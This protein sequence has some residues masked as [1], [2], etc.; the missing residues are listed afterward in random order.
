[1]KSKILII[2]SACS[3]TKTCEYN[4]GSFAVIKMTVEEI[5]KRIPK[6]ELS[7]L[8]QL[9]KDN[10]LRNK[11]FIIENK[12]RETRYYSL[13]D[14]L[15]MDLNV[16]SCLLYRILQRVNIEANFMK[17]NKIIRAFNDAD[18]IIDLSLDAFS[19]D[20]G[21]RSIIE[22]SKE[23]L[24]GIFLD[25]PV[26]VY[27]QSLG[28][29]NNRLNRFIARYVLNRTRII[30]VRE[31]VSFHYIQELGLDGPDIYLTADQAFLLKPVSSMEL[32][33]ILKSENI[34]EW[35]PTVGI[36]LSKMKEF[37]QTSNILKKIFI[38]GY[39]I[40]MYLLPEI[41]VKSLHNQI[42]KSKYLQKVEPNFG[43]S[44]IN[45]VIEHLVKT[46]DA[47]II[48]IPHI[49]S[50]QHELMGD[51][52]TTIQNVYNHMKIVNKKERVIPILNNYSSEELKGIIGICD[53]FIGEKMHANVGALSQCIPTIGL[54]YSHKFQGIMK[55]LGQEN[56]VINSID[57]NEIIDKIDL[58]WKNKDQIKSE[59]HHNVDEMKKMAQFNCDLLIDLLNE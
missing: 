57:S 52:R 38:K 13:F 18:V 32:S 12:V 15:S 53:I 25:K 47:R 50:P 31:Q 30:T 27:A 51:D 28:P 36:A 46:Y 43:D 21:T 26:Y 10:P 48:L 59:L 3:C 4:R 29:F 45:D 1:M 22:T 20:Y 35:Y 24:I 37:N 56:Y 6:A 17:K 8:I 33:E 2:K 14:S 11:V 34:Q 16:L 7:T 54:S 55:M 41:I 58:L 42:K 49:I 19:D 5:K 44:W 23:I 40:V 9:S 39:S